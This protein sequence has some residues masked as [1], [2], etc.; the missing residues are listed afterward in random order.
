MG[1]HKPPELTCLTS[2]SLF[3]LLNI[4]YLLLGIVMQVDMTVRYV[5]LACHKEGKKAPDIV[6]G[7]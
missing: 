1:T 5:Q 6:Y 3:S 4:M 7:P 2:I